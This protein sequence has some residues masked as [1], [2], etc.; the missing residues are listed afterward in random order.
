M[1]VQI[2]EKKY[3]PKKWYQK[4][5]TIIQK[6]IEKMIK[7]QQEF[8]IHRAIFNPKQFSYENRQKPYKK[9]K[10]FHTQVFIINLSPLIFRDF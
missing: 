3:R 8:R 9:S 2:R 4:I 6:T 1:F 7:I 5:Y 10:K